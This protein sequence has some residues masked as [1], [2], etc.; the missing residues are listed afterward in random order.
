MFRVGEYKVTPLVEGTLKVD[1][2]VLFGIV[3]RN[4]WENLLVPDIENCV[5]LPITAFLIQGR[6][7]NILLD[8]GFG[9]K[10]GD[11]QLRRAGIGPIAP[12]PTLLTAQGVAPEEIDTV[13]LSHLHATVAGGLT[14]LNGGG[15]L[16]VYKNAVHWVQTGEWEQAVHPNLR[17]NTVYFRENYESLLWLKSLSFID[18]DAEIVPGIRAVRSGGH[19][20]HHQVL[21]VESKGEGAVFWCDLIPTTR[22]L[23]LRAVPA[24]DIEPLRTMESKAELLHIAVSKG[25]MS[26]FSRDPDFV[27]GQLVPSPTETEE[28]RLEP[29]SSQE[30][31]QPSDRS[32]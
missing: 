5:R 16:P 14:K 27:V 6:G 22:H 29:L 10:L 3:P 24:V 18:G 23:M 7:H 25:W 8:T 19:T 17:T 2:G 4:A 20:Q 31:A 30:L 32:C 21:I 1:G 12:L 15:V 28:L 26:V 11:L 9:T 13:V